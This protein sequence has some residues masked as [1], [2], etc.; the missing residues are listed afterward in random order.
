MA[1]DINPVSRDF[2]DDSYN[3]IE[4]KM[5]PVDRRGSRL[6]EKILAEVLNQELN[7]EPLAG[8]RLPGN[9]LDI[10]KQL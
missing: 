3:E 10:A 2:R 8:V 1:S 5:K 9:V 7:K 4:N 6:P